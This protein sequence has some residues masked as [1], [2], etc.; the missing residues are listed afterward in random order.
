M[1]E[2]IVS[3]RKIAIFL[4]FVMGLTLLILGGVY[5]PYTEYVDLPSGGFRGIGFKLYEGEVAT[6]N[7]SSFDRFT[8]YIMN[9]TEFEKLLDNGTFNGSYYTATG[10]SMELEFT[11]PRT[12]VYYIV[13]AN[14]NSKGGIEVEFTFK[15]SINW[16]FSIIGT[17]IVLLASIFLFLELRNLVKR[18]GTNARCPECGM[19]VNTSWNYCPYCGTE[20]RRR[21]DEN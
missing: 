3:S 1:L 16:T 12:G 10:R 15:K 11:P 14:F 13:I 8:V 5:N 17:V 6:Y 20:L 19:E 4:I 18:P 2:H 9:K 7:L 21:E